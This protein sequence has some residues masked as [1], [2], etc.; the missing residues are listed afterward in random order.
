VRR[1]G[2]R[3]AWF[4]DDLVEAVLDSPIAARLEALD[5]SLGTLTVA[6]ALRLAEAAPRLPLLIRLDVDDNYL[7]H[8]ALRTIANAFPRTCVTSR[9]QKVRSGSLAPS[10]TPSWERAAPIARIGTA[11]A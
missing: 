3:N 5:L 11:T 8:A 7:T 6:G 10:F 2:L 1:L 4:A 9:Q